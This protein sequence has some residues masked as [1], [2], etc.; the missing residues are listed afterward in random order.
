MTAISR[1][2]VAASSKPLVLSILAGRE[3]YGYE[4]IGEVKRLSGGDL[5]WTDGMLY[6]VLHR[7]EREGLVESFWRKSDTGRDR[8]YYRLKKAGLKE[9]ESQKAQWQSVNAA[10]AQLWDERGATCTA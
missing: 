5:E 2:L 8:K 7:L 6:P 3:S 1:E 9:I 4:I 10:L